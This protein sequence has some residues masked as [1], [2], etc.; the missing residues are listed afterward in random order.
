MLTS[1]PY[2][3]FLARF[4]YFRL[5]LRRG[6]ELL[7]NSTA[8][9][10]KKQK[11]KIRLDELVELFK[12]NGI[13]KGKSIMVH[14][15]FSRIEANVEEFTEFLQ[16]LVGIEG[17]VCMPT[18]P[19]LG[20]NNAEKIYD[21]RLS[22]S[23]VGY[24]TEYFRKQ[25]G[26]C[27]SLHPYSSLAVWG[28]DKDFLLAGNLNDDW[29]LP[30][31][32]YSGYYKFAQLNGIVVCIG[33]T[34]RSNATIRHVAEEVVDEGLKIQNLFVRDSVVIYNDGAFIKEAKVRHLNLRKSQLYVAKGKII[35]EWLQNQILKTYCIRGI[36]VEFIDAKK[37]VEYM[38]NQIYLGNTPFPLAPKNR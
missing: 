22:H 17:N 1:N 28:K 20:C 37:C 38:I 9:F 34:A 33:V 30:H 8:K 24:L 7:K 12:E 2:V 19:I 29:P 16:D 35:N 26:V 5:G 10:S 3:E 4:L 13:C 25:E 14:T 27:R 6:F 23:S 18:H 32:K 15:A 21:V 36:P 11:S 31:G